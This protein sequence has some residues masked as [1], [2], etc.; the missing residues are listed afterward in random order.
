MALT[1]YD[2][3]ATA[4]AVFSAPAVTGLQVTSINLSASPVQTEFGDDPANGACTLFGVHDRDVVTGTISGR[5]L[6]NGLANATIGTNV[7]ASVAASLLVVAGYTGNN[8]TVVCTGIQT[9]A[10]P[11]AFKTVSF[12]IT[13]LRS[14]A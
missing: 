8:G 14:I 6:A 9:Q 4:Q 2:T 11:G 5:L 7:T 3:A 13:H 10:Q 12:D 1:I